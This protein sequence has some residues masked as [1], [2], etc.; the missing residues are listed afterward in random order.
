MTRVGMSLKD[1]AREFIEEIIDNK[2]WPKCLCCDRLALDGHFTCG[3]S[4]CNEA[5]AREHYL[6]IR[7][8][9]QAVRVKIA[10]NQ[11]KI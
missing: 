3:G 7:F 10:V 8:R 2:D 4:S 9:E 11:I 1:R 6:S 5:K